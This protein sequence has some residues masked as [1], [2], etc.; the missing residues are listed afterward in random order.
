MPTEIERKFLV[1][2]DSWKKNISRTVPI[3]QGYLANTERGSIRVRIADGAAC[4][5]IKSMTIGITR[6]EYE[7]AIP[8]GDAENLMQNFCLQPLI[9][10]VRYYV[11]VDEHTWEIDVFEGENMGLVIAEIELTDSEEIFSKPDWV[12]REVSDEPRYYNI[13]LVEHPYRKWG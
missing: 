13:C 2:G 7:Y 1:I 9:E 5:N 4:L 3:K 6:T 12:G 8:M 11:E 10:K